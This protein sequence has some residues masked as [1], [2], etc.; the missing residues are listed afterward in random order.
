MMKTLLQFSPSIGVLEL[1]VVALA[2]VV[3][4][5]LLVGRRA[6]VRWWIAGFVSVLV[7]ALLTPADF[8]STVVLGMVL[9]GMYLFGNRG[10]SMNKSPV[11]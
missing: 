1:A 5:V 6:Y 10:G 9:F 3:V 2:A 7:A 8:L 11:G 4:I